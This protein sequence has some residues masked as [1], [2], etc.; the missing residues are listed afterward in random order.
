MSLDIVGPHQILAAVNDERSARSPA[1]TIEV[2]S[3][4]KGP[5]RM[6]SGL[7]IVADCAYGGANHAH[8]RGLDT[9]IVAGGAGVAAAMN[10][11][12]MID[13]IR[14]AAKQARRIVS[15][16]SGTFLLAEAGLLK[17]KRVT[18]HWASCARLAQ[19]YPN[20]TVE[21]DPIFV[22]DGK[23]W[24]SAGVTAGMDLALALVED[25]FGHEMALR[26][27][28]RHVLYMIR[29]GGQAQF[30]AQLAAQSKAGGRL[31]EVISW[32]SDHLDLDLSVPSLASRAAMS[33]RTFA[34]AFRAETGETPARFIE[35]LRLEAAR[36]FLTGS[37]LSVE[38][39]AA[40]CGFGSAERM[41]RSFQRQVRVSPNTYRERFRAHAEK[42]I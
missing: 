10:D 16:C 39:V 12:E 22:R 18:T 32:I 42:N 20:I 8:W 37:S 38:A 33:E 36:R 28:R 29:P 40:H 9:L 13:V 31:V 7:A 6:S 11:A 4:K 21:T 23:I 3:Q 5:L 30:S 17:G 14:N 27:A 19:R 41:R 25:D 24:T 35:K 1:Y 15:V 2:A 34:R 26:I